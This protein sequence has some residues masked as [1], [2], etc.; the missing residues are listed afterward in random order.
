VSKSPS[1]RCGMISPLGY[2]CSLHPGHHGPHLGRKKDQ[3]VM[4]EQAKLP[5]GK[6]CDQC[7]SLDTFWYRGEV[8]C[9]CCRARSG[10]V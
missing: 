2:P 1:S 3:T 7:G 10:P 6:Y 9:S 5:F 4:W 8:V